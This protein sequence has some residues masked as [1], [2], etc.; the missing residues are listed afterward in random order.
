ML[1]KNKKWSK[2][3]AVSKELSGEAV[4]QMEHFKQSIFESVCM[5][6]EVSGLTTLTLTVRWAIVTWG[7]VG[8]NCARKETR[9]TCTLKKF[10]SKKRTLVKTQISFVTLTYNGSCRGTGSCLI[11]WISWFLEEESQVNKLNLKNRKGALSVFKN[12]TI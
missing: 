4:N 2:E 9:A 5:S 1:G 8:G 6:L 3:D 11:N 12:K 7:T 10:V